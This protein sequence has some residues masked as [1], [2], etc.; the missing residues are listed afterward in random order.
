MY[1]IKNKFS[2]PIEDVTDLYSIGKIE[3]TC[4]HKIKSH[5]I[6]N[7]FDPNDSWW[8]IDGNFISYYYVDTDRYH[9]DDIYYDQYYDETD[10]GLIR[11]VIE[12]YDIYIRD[13]KLNELINN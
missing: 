9:N 13:K 2:E 6:S 12:N 7:I 8:D 4:Y 10:K 11:D 3:Y 5:G 1:D